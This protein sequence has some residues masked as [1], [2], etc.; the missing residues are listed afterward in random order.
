[1]AAIRSARSTRPRSPPPRASRPRCATASPPRPLDIV[2]PEAN[3]GDLL[4]HHAE[5]VRIAVA[6]R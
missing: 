6:A 5:E 4:D 2:A 1:M 3:L